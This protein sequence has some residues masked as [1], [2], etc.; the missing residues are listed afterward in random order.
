[1]SAI[2]SRLSIKLEG[3]WQT[4]QDTSKVDRHL[5]AASSAR[6]LIS[7]LLH[8]LSP[9]EKVYLMTWFKSKTS[10]G[11]PTQKQ[12]ARYAMLGSNTNLNEETLEPIYELSK[13]IRNTYKKLNK[14]AH[15]R[16]YD[17]SLDTL[18]ESLI[19]QCQTYLLKLLEMRSSNFLA[20]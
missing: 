19:D 12:R 10:N 11:K 18:T 6:E 16:D 2:E 3:S 9:D 5:Q 7:D 14:I 8:T 1:M 20:N 13:G 17:K 4:L 15:R